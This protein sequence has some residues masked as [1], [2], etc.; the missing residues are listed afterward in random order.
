MVSKRRRSSCTRRRSTRRRSSSSCPSRARPHTFAT[1][2]RAFQ[3][4][5]D[6]EIDKFEDRHGYGPESFDEYK[7]I[8]RRAGAAYRKHYGIRRR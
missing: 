3:V 4:F 2:R 5:R 1:G 7:G 6:K 8:A